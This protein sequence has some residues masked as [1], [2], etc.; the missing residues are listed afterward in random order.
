MVILS[1]IPSE[2]RSRESH[3]SPIVLLRTCLLDKS[4]DDQKHR[5]VLPVSLLDVAA[6]LAV[7]PPS[8][9][10][11]GDTMPVVIGDVPTYPVL[12]HWPVK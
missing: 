1:L 4:L 10:K 11:L 6:L 2:L 5:Q 7:Q 3:L 9:P 8:S 12:H